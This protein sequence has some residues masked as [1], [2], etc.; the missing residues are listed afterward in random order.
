MITKE[1][2]KKII[3]EWAGMYWHE[4]HKDDEK[5]EREEAKE[6]FEWIERAE[7]KV[8]PMTGAEELAM[9]FHQIY[10]ELAPKL[11]YETR[12]ESA[13]PWK[14]V[15]ENNQKLM[16]AVAEEIMKRF[17]IPSLVK[18]HEVDDFYHPVCGMGS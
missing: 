14:D 5:R 11:G 18:A 15:P 2:I 17:F 10:E 1:K 8:K 13:V 6:L 16:I 3:S 12:K 4:Y 9:N 7:I